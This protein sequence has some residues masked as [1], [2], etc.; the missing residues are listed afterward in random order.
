MATINFYEINPDTFEDIP[1]GSVTIENGNITSEHEDLLEIAQ[2]SGPTSEDII[3]KL[4]SWSNGYIRTELA[5]DT[6]SEDTGSEVEASVD[7]VFEEMESE[8]EGSE[9]VPEIPQVPEVPSHFDGKIIL[10][11]TFGNE[12]SK[13]Q[14]ANDY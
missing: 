2:A 1:L 7:T 5:G 12:L 13:D 6:E 8:V 14:I 3:E 9:T 10:K 11:R 4:S